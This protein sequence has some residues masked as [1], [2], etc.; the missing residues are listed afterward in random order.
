MYITVGIFYA[1]SAVLVFGRT[2]NYIALLSELSGQ[3]FIVQAF[4]ARSEREKKQSIELPGG[5]PNVLSRISSIQ[6]RAAVRIHG[7]ET[8]VRLESNNKEQ[9]FTLPKSALRGE[10]MQELPL[11]LQK[12]PDSFSGDDVHSIKIRAR[13][14]GG[15]STWSEELSTSAIARQQGADYAQQTLEQ[16]MERRVPEKLAQVLQDVRDIE[17]ED[18]SLVSQATEL[19]QIL[20]N[21]QKEVEE[22][23]A[24]R[25]P[26]RLQE[27]LSH[28]HEVSLPGLEEAE[29]L[30][31]TLQRV[32]RN[33]DTA[34]G[35]DAL[36]AALREGHEARLPAVLLQ[37]AV[38]RLGTREA[39]Q[40]GLEMAIEAARVPVVTAALETAKDMHLPSE[41]AARRLLAAISNSENLLQAAL[42]SESIRDLENALDSAASSGLREDELIHR[43]Q[44][45]LAQQL[46]IRQDAEKQLEDAMEA[47]RPSMLR[48]ALD[49]S[50]RSQVDDAKTQE[51]EDL[52]KQLQFL[53]FKLEAAVG[54]EERAATLQAAQAKVP[55]ELLAAAEKQLNCLNEL[56]RV[57]AAGD[58]PGTRRA[59]KLAEMAGV[60]NEEIAKAHEVQRRWGELTRELEIAVSMGNTERLQTALSNTENSGI[61]E[62]QLKPARNLLG[63]FQRSDAAFLELDEEDQL[64]FSLEHPLQPK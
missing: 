37:R 38:Q 24:A 53:L 28:A 58:V 7:R 64:P 14:P 19:L 17:F 30:L 9:S 29:E 39:A 60:K 43:A 61:S 41:E 18:K 54:S 22:A 44:K 42:Q 1:V 5:E 11:D 8:V 13:N 32:C 31:D 25:D 26:E 46:Q 52:L 51:G 40:Q 2:G 56:H 12:M 21:V 49:V 4:K 57:L 36:R 50:G 10:K 47:R 62:E 15:W 6:H 16:A 23:M 33:L 48:E 3:T 45:L 27:A 35:I 20:Q 55:R 63:A 59:L 34:R